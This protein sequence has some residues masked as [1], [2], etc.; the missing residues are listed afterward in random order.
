MPLDA[1]FS[2]P[3][4]DFHAAGSARAALNVMVYFLGMDKATKDAL[5]KLTEIV[6]RG[7]AAV[8]EDIA[9]IRARMATPFQIRSATVQA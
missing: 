2:L 3:L 7:F 9:D 5:A 1:S 4:S 8:S 6:E